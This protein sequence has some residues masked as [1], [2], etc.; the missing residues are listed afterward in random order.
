[1]PLSTARPSNGQVS[2]KAVKVVR[3]YLGHKRTTRERAD[4]AARTY[5]QKRPIEAPTLQQLAF[6]YRVS[7]ASIQRRLNGK[8]VTVDAAVASWR[9]WTPEQRAEFGR[10]AGIGNLWDFAIIPTIAEER[11]H[12]QAAE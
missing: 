9:V 5:V 1:M 7:V 8:H 2:V 11:A 4:L 12:Q 3:G 10:G 6:A